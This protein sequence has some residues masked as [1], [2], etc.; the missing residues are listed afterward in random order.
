MKV[1]CLGRPAHCGHGELGEVGGAGRFPRSPGSEGP[2]RCG[3]GLRVLSQESVNRPC[4]HHPG[5]PSAF[6]CSVGG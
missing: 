3:W 2:E 1:E 6:L 4:V 5:C